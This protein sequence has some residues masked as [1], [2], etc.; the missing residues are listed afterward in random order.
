MKVVKEAKKLIIKLE[1]LDSRKA[2]V[3]IEGL[4][5]GLLLHKHMLRVSV[6]WAIAAAFNG[7]TGIISA[8]VGSYIGILS[9]LLF[10]VFYFISHK[11]IKRLKQHR[12]GLK[13]VIRFINLEMVIEEIKSNC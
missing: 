5:A 7:F 3:N 10:V 4:S 8:I 12:Q 2:K 11:A 6:Y 9:F 1:T 13:M